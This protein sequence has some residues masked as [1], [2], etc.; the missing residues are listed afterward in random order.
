MCIRDSLY[1]G[2]WAKQKDHNKYCIFLIF[3]YIWILAFTFYSRLHR[4]ENVSNAEPIRAHSKEYIGQFDDSNKLIIDAEHTKT[5]QTN[6]D[7]RNLQGINQNI[8]GKL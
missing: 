4:N 5:M 2:N 7:L 3:C 8:L 1:T 6:N